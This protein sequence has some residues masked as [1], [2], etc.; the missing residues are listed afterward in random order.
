[1]A[2]A[3]AFDNAGKSIPARLA[4]MAI[5]T[6]SSIKVKPLPR[7]CR[8]LGPVALR[9]RF[10]AY[11]SIPSP[12]AEHKGNLAAHGHLI[13]VRRLRASEQARTCL[14]TRNARPEPG[15]MAPK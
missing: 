15:M 6:S 8:I 1:M 4:M 14:T 3:L 5:T 9:V 7:R 10:M 11:L 12:A 2:L 13:A